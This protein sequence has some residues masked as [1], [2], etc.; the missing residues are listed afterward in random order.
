M[1]PVLNAF[2]ERGWPRRIDDPLPGSSDPQRLRE[3][4]GSMNEG[5]AGI[6]FRAD[7]FGR[8]VLWERL[9]KRG[10]SRSRRPK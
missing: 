1:I 6:Y 9:P 10:S 3:T 4:I 2:E 5:L 8:G 7:G